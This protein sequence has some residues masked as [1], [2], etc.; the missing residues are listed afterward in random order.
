M[1]SLNSAFTLIELSIVLVIIGL[2]VGGVMTGI[3]LVNAAN[4]RAQISQIEKYQTAVHTFQLKY[5]YLPGDIP[6]PAASGFGFVIGHRGNCAGTGDGDGLLEGTWTCAGQGGQMGNGE[7]AMFWSDLSNAGLIDQ[8]FNFAAYAD[9]FINITTGYYPKAKLSGSVYVS[10]M[11]CGDW[12][13][14]VA[15]TGTN[16]FIISNVGGIGTGP[17]EIAGTPSLTVQQAY[18]IDSKIDDGMPQTGNV[19][20][21]YMCNANNGTTQQCWSKD[22]STTTGTWDGTPDTSALLPS[23]T[24]CYDNGNVAGATQQYSTGQNGGSGVNCALSFKFQ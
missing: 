21:R 8:K 5:G 23:V 9:T 24:T 10:D 14:C 13:T 11:A 18:A 3:D 15:A 4:I 7:I 20:T 6:E 2:I 1:T 17:V 16:Y 22:S 19:T 12:P